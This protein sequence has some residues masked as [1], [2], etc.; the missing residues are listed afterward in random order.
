MKNLT[1]KIHHVA[2]SVSDLQKSYN[3]YRKF[4]FEKILYWQDEQKTLEIMHLKLNDFI[5]EIF[6]FKNFEKIYFYE[7]QLQ[8][9]LPRIWVK[10]FW[11]Q[12]ENL[13]EA[14]K[15]FEKEK[16]A[17]NIEIKLWRTGIKY[18]FIKDPDGILLEF[19]EDKRNLKFN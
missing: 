10:H 19:V 7:K 6:C 3:F 13:E 5:L 15:F 2:I 9:S 11:I 18:F 17:E 1:F 16:I 8:T 14:K 12:V 4:W